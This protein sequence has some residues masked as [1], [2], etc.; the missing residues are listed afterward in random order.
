MQASVLS[1]RWCII[2][3]FPRA[4]RELRGSAGSRARVLYKGRKQLPQKRLG[5]VQK[6]SILRI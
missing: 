3:W 5:N 2:P 4:E 6:I 1:G